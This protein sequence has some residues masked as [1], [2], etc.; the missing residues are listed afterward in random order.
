M[1]A[2]TRAPGRAHRALCRDAA[3]ARPELLAPGVLE[4]ELRA[5][6]WGYLRGAPAPPRAP[7]AGANATR[8]GAAARGAAA[9]P[10][11]ARS[12]ERE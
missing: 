9:V 4:T 3:T 12:A 11:R 8:R 7:A 5:L 2:G 1:S 6:V 10:A